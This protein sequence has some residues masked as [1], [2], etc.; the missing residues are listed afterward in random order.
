MIGALGGT[1]H[2]KYPP[3]VHQNSTRKFFLKCPFLKHFV[4]LFSIFQTM[5][6]WFPHG[7]VFV[8]VLCIWHNTIL[9][10]VVVTWFRNSLPF[11]R[12][13]ILIV[14]GVLESLAQSGWEAGDAFRMMTT[15]NHVIPF[16][17]LKVIINKSLG[18]GHGGDDT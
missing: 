6:T 10:S 15:C 8:F 12:L 16:P 18:N 5:E 13:G 2:N 1:G 3:L 9:K 17:S 7:L 4:L 14:R 11:I